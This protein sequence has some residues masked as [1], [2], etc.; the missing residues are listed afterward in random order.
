MAELSG[1]TETTLVVVGWIAGKALLVELL[2]RVS[3]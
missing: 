3:V 2:F 1:A